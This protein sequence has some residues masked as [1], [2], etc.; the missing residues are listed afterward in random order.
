MLSMESSFVDEICTLNSLKQCKK[1]GLG[2]GKGV[3][4]LNRAT[5]YGDILGEGV[6]VAV[7]VINHSIWCR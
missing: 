1:F 6:F 4:E 3:S 2:K 5:L 7:R